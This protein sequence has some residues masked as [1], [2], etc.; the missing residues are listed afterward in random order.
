[1]LFPFFVCVRTISVITACDAYGGNV[2]DELM[3]GVVHDNVHAR[4]ANHF[5]QLIPST[6]D[7]APLGHEGSDF[8]VFVQRQHGNVVTE[9]GQLRLWNVRTDLLCYEQYLFCFHRFLTLLHS[10]FRAQRYKKKVKG[11]SCELKNTY[12]NIKLCNKWEI[13]NG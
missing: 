9:F 5:V 8:A 1:M 3:V 11:E 12:F 7:V 6:I 13:T 4:Q 10:Y 2:D